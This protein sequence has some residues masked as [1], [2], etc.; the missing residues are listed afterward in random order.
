MDGFKNI[1]RQASRKFLSVKAQILWILPRNYFN[2]SNDQ[3]SA[4]LQQV[5][6]IW[7]HDHPVEQK[8][9][10]AG[11]S[12]DCP[13]GDTFGRTQKMFYLFCQRTAT[14]L[15]ASGQ[16]CVC[17]IDNCWFAETIF[18]L[19]SANALRTYV[20]K[21]APPIGWRAHQADN[22]GCWLLRILLI[23]LVWSTGPLLIFLT[24]VPILP[25]SAVH[26]E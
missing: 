11:A 18:T 12:E 16:Q 5:S 7:S 2:T 3:Q 4:Q 13:P 23:F 14:A 15:W 10:K 1:C 24:V 19:R 21:C 8:E 25:W 20:C 6:E 26:V 22:R 17:G 9:Q